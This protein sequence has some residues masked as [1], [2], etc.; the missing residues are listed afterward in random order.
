MIGRRFRAVL[1]LIALISGGLF[2]AEQIVGQILDG[3]VHHESVGDAAT[4]STQSSGDHGHEDPASDHNDHGPGH[5]HG[6]TAD[7][8]T[9]HHSTAVPCTFSF[10]LVFSIKRTSSSY[11]VSLTATHIQAILRP[12]ILG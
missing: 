6:T 2:N 7:H 1:A 8:C 10:P 9:H 5:S 12:P 11:D 4:H 3:D